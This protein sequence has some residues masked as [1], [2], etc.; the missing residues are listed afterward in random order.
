MSEVC[1]FVIWSAA[2]RSTDAILADLGKRF[3]LADVV[4]LTWPPESF[5]RN[6]TR[7]YGD[8]L[9]PGSD[10]ERMCG[11]GPFLVVLAVDARPRYGL[12]RTTSG[13]RRVNVRAAAAKR[14]YRRLSGGGFGVHS[15]LDEHEARRDLRLLL[16]L[17]PADVMD[18]RWDGTIRAVMV[19]RLV[20]SSV[21]DLL[22]AIVSATPASLALDD[23]TTI[24]VETEDPW[25]AAVIAGGDAPEPYTREA[26][27]EVSIDGR[28]RTL[29]LVIS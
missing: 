5:A 15:S 1:V 20:W 27:V 10:K 19:D 25:W 8:A 28:P 7:F 12:R 16:G 21:D 2:R 18:R 23:G 9:P 6:L 22:S 4:E 24:V 11:T 26:Q 29:R 14:R 3:A 17:D 13:F